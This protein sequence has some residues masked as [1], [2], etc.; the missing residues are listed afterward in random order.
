VEYRI[1]RAIDL[2]LL[3]E[4]LFKISCELGNVPKPQLYF[5]EW[6]E[7]NFRFLNFPTYYYIYAR[8][9]I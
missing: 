8:S 1:L 3:R 4:C 2:I 6:V 7:I 9:L 5:N